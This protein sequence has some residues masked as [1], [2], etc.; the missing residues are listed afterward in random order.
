VPDPL[1]DSGMRWITNQF[2]PLKN[3]FDPDLEDARDIFITY[4]TEKQVKKAEFSEEKSFRGL[5]GITLFL[6]PVDKNFTA[7]VQSLGRP[8]NKYYSDQSASLVGDML[9]YNDQDKVFTFVYFECIVKPS[10]KWTFEIKQ[11]EPFSQGLFS[12]L[13]DARMF[14]MTICIILIVIYLI[15]EVYSHIKLQIE[16]RKER[17]IQEAEDKGREGFRKEKV[18]E[19]TD[20][21]SL[22]AA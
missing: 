9:M 4:G 22:I 14:M 21:H 12:P 17:K 6:D 20:D 15:S 16:L 7:V 3:S 5:G 13:V 19:A 1:F 2:D 10:G 18:C 8:E 11:I